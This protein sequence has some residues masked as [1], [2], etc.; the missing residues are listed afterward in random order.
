MKKCPKCGSESTTI[1]LKW[2][3]FDRKEPAVRTLKCLMCGYEERCSD[4]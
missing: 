1:Y 4:A 3:P 2:L